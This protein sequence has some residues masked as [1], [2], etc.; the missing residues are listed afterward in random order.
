M[1]A[2]RFYCPLLLSEG[3]E[4][5]LPAAAARHAQVLRLQPGQTVILFGTDHGQWQARI[6]AMGKNSVHVQALS[7]EAIACEAERSVHLAV[8]LIANERMDYLIEKATEL[9]VASFRPVLAE[10]CVMR[11]SGERADKR[12]AHWQAIAVAA[13]EQSGRNTV[14]P[15][16]P[17]QSLSHYLTSCAPLPGLKGLLSLN[18][19]GQNLHAFA[20]SP[21][22]TPPVSVHLLSG[23]EGG[24]TANEEDLAHQFGFSDV[25]LVGRT[26]RADTAPLAALAALV[27]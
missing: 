14:P 6:T 11:L 19:Q 24:W 16:L 1:A 15:V 2:P 8:G 18:P 3:L 17:V 7:H 4:L 25:R 13:C 26:L 5:E 27:L 23:T 21:L 22:Q 12:V 9:G 20:Q 10:R